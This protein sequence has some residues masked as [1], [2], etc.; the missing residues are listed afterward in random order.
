M[1]PNALEPVTAAMTS[2]PSSTSPDWL[3]TSRPLYRV[4]GVRAVDRAI[5]DRHGIPGPELM[6]RAAAFA[7]DAAR[8]RWPAAR[9]LLVL[10]GPGN[11][12]GDG[13]LLARL[14]HRARMSVRVAHVAGAWPPTNDA[15]LALDALRA[16]GLDSMPWDGEALPAADLVVDALLGTGLTRPPTGEMAA[17]I[18]AVNAGSAPVLA[19][20]TPSG[21]DLDR[22]VAPGACIRADLT[23][24]FIV[25]KP[26]LHTGVARDVCG[27][28]RL[29]DLDAP[30]EALSAVTADAMLIDETLLPVMLVPRRRTAHKGDHGR[31]LLLGG[32]HGYAGAIRLAGEAAARSGAGL[33]SIG[34]RASHQALIAAAVPELMARGVETAAELNALLARQDVLAVGP[35]L[36]QSEWA[37]MVFEGA[38]SHRGP[39]VIDADG[40]N[41]LARAGSGAGPRRDDRVLTPHPGEAARLLGST[42][43]EVESDR[44]SHANR[45]VALYGGVCVLKG[46]GTV[47]ASADA[48]ALIV[49]GGNPGLAAGG[50]GDVLTGIIAALLAQGLSP[51]QAAATGAVVHASAGDRA[52]HHGERGMLASDVIDYLR[53]AVNP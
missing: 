33:T 31:V 21:L 26:G 43:A 24:T 52:A 47:V 50:S 12:G 35:G 7:L 49:A 38:C 10:C 19:L 53:E 2:V 44:V 37:D 29:G 23:T 17:L 36:G 32:D 34:T 16:A 27:D 40:L 18:E 11:N 39:M 8:A 45:I 22:G 3:R 9:R 25:D 5:I 42:I 30:A 51:L 41:R 6:G 4:A 1:L 15:L 20:D 48:P 13:F 28:V 14:A 46:A